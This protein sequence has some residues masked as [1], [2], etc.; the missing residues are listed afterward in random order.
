MCVT[1]QSAEWPLETP[2]SLIPPGPPALPL[3]ASESPPFLVIDPKP[4]HFPALQ[5]LRTFLPRLSPPWCQAPTL[6][7]PFSGL[8]SAGGSGARGRPGPAPQSSLGRRVGGALASGGWGHTGSPPS[9]R[10]QRKQR[11]RFGE[12]APPP[13]PALPPGIRAELRCTDA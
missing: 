6:P 8:Y 13:R 5:F 2:M 1:W 9:P 3:S 4:L 12:E 11:G 10:E 7:F